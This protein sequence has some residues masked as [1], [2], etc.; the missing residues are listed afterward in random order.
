[1]TQTRHVTE[2]GSC[3]IW[4]GLAG[5]GGVWRDL[6]GSGG[7]RWGLVGCG[8]GSGILTVVKVSTRP[9]SRAYCP[10]MLAI[11]GRTV[12]R[13]NC[14]PRACH[15]REA[16]SPTGWSGA[17]RILYSDVYNAIA[18]SATPSPTQSAMRPIVLLATHGQQNDACVETRAWAAK[19][20]V[21]GDALCGT[22]RR[23]VCSS[24]G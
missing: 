12:P 11:A 14:C 8:G 5:S 22:Q 4:W 19:R 24:I 10:R 15:K 21:S 23:C 6:A 13:K 17:C 18:P 2:S 1:M 9:P 3:G 20:C 7:V 16:F